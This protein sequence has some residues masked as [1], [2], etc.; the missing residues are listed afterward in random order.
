MKKFSH[1]VLQQC[2]YAF[3]Y[4][5]SNDIVVDDKLPLDFKYTLKHYTLSQDKGCMSA[6]CSWSLLCQGIK[7]IFHLANLDGN[8]WKPDN[9]I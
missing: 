2:F 3:M 4:N 1:W 6:P 8:P 5:L 7:N 9:V